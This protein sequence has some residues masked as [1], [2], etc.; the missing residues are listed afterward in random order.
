MPAPGDYKRYSSPVDHDFLYFDLKVRTPKKLNII[1]QLLFGEKLL[2]HFYDWHSDDQ[3][4]MS[5][6]YRMRDVAFLSIVK[7]TIARM[8]SGVNL[9]YLQSTSEHA[10]RSGC[11]MHSRFVSS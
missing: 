9:S 5:M 1:D 10:G 4:K 11:F 3:A 8:N 2:R 6:P 7:R